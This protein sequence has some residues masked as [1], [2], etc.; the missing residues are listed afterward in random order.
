MKMHK[1]VTL[2]RVMKLCEQQSRSLDDPGICIECGQGAAGVEPDAREYPCAACGA[3][4]V[5]GA[6]ELLVQL[7][8]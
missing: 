2:D 5:Y 3:N 1:S 6:E 4:A 7:A 8:L